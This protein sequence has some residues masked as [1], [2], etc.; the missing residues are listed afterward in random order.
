MTRTRFH[1]LIEQRLIQLDGAT[2]TELVKRGM[3]AGVC[4]EAWV[5][6]HPEALAA[7][8]QAY[9]ASGSDLV[10]APTFGGNPLKLAEFH[11]EQQTGEINRQLAEISRRAV[12]GKLVFGDIAPTGQLVEPFGP[13]P[14]EKTVELYKEQVRGLIDGG[15][16]GFAIETMMDLQEAR[17]ALI[18]VRE[19]SDLPA[20][21]TLTFEPGG[22]TL[23]GVHPVSA[24]VTLQALGADAFGC[25][26]STG[27]AE[28]AEVIRELK[29]YAAI[30]LVAKPNAGMPHLV[31]G[32]TVFDLAPDAFAKASVALIDAGANLLGGCCGTSPA[33]L[34]ALHNEISSRRPLPVRQEKRGVVTSPSSFRRLALEEPFAIIG[35]R[36]NPTGK[37]ALQA[38]LRA[39]KFELVREFAR[40]QSAQR[41]A[42]LDVNFGLSGIDE[43]AMMRAGV[44]ELVRIGSTPLCIDSTRPETVEAAL[45]LYPGRALLNSISAEEERLNKVLPIAAKYGAM[46]ILLPLTDDGIPESAAERIE[47]L[48]RILAEAARYGYTPA[49]CAADALIMTISADRQAAAVSLDF[50]EH[51]SRQLKL[52]TVCGLSNVSFGLP[53]RATVNLTFLG[54]A[55]GRGLN[56]AIANPSAPGIVDAVIASDALSG[57]DPQLDRYLAH[58]AVAAS[59][60]TPRQ[61]TPAPAPAAQSPEELL[62]DAVLRGKKEAVPAILDTLIAA[63]K[64][65]GELVDGILIPAITEVGNRFERKEYFLPQLMQSAAAMQLAME[66]LEPLLRSGGANAAGPVFLLATVKGD[67]H[68]IG[69]NIVALL[70]KNHHFQVID[71]GKDVPAE[72]IVNAAIEHDA[73]FIGLSALMTTTMPQMKVV[74]DLA[75]SRGVTA[76][77]IVGG[78]AVDEAFADSIGAIYAADAMATVRRATELLQAGEKR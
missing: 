10:Y 3:P 36:I 35:E 61:T 17:A 27:P 18:A 54:M 6:E 9:A 59:S 13:L 23:T 26:C 19:L 46:L 63:G 51:C 67:I 45:R 58:H 44:A 28:M 75:R 30:P 14:F 40:E 20:I 22:R 16:D 8:Q 39:G 7:V 42:L 29:P 34:A 50:I 5:L 74:V 68:D 12:P 31:D 43:T 48:D 72:T 33:H 57:R 24:L 55:I 38:E 1:A 52:N 2:G 73:A 60:E 78:A 71:L 70:L 47:V 69:K 32:T 11:L 62:R 4:P 66:Q 76:P 49:D 41:A 25:N 15:V 64:A 56:C 53:A 77:V 37:K 21:V 65:P